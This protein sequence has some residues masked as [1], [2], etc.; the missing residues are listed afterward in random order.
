MSTTPPV[1]TDKKEEVS[2]VSFL[3]VF[4]NLAFT[5]TMLLSAIVHQGIY[6]VVEKFKNDESLKNSSVYSKMSIYDITLAWVTIGVGAF[7]IITT[8]VRYGM[9]SNIDPTD[10]K[11]PNPDRSSGQIIRS[12][13]T[14]AVSLM[15][16]ISITMILS[17]DTKFSSLS[18]EYL[19]WVQFMP[20]LGIIFITIEQMYSNYKL[21]KDV[22]ESAKQTIRVCDNEWAYYDEQTSKGSSDAINKKNMLKSIVEK[23]DKCIAKKNSFGNDENRIKE[24]IDNYCTSKGGVFAENFKK[25]PNHALVCKHLKHNCDFQKIVDAFEETTAPA[26]ASKA[27]AGSTV[28]NIN[29]NP[30]TALQ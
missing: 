29:G 20:W 7:L 24:H 5:I 21:E 22:K 25:D 28:V 2:T 12:L 26:E 27:A 23:Y 14:C 30:P 6:S 16:I 19:G 13:L 15:T 10:P 8:V 18:N 11:K 9:S 3:R 4:S 17:P 1:V